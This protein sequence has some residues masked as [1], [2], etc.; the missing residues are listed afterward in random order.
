MAKIAYLFL[1]LLMFALIQGTEKSYYAIIK[2]C[3]G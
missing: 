1:F 3:A 2:S